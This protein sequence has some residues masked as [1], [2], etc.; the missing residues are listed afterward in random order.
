MGGAS[1]SD[2]EQP[3]RTESTVPVR[4][5]IQSL[6]HVLD[7]LRRFED[8]PTSRARNDDKPPA[9]TPGPPDSGAP[10]GR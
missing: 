5:T 3:K 1:E 8:R 9:D 7:V 4:H 6:A 10:G 2:N